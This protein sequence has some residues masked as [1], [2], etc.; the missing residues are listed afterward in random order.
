MGLIPAKPCA[1]GCPTTSGALPGSEAPASLLRLARCGDPAAQGG[2]SATAGRRRPGRPRAGSSGSSTRARDVN[3]CAY[4][5]KAAPVLVASKLSDL[6]GSGK[7]PG[8]A[9]PTVGNGGERVSG[10]G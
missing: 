5:F 4:L 10:C 8:V 9:V 2:R 6:M 3:G 1:P 7:R